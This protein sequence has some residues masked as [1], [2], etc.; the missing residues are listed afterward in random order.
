MNKKLT[1]WII[2]IVIVFS[3]FLAYQK[4]QGN[5]P[6]LPFQNYLGMP[7]QNAN[8]QMGQ[9]SKAITEEITDNE[10][11]APDLSVVGE[12]GY[13]TGSELA[14]AQLPNATIWIPGQ[15]DVNIT[16][17]NGFPVEGGE[18][19]G[20]Y[21]SN[22]YYAERETGDGKD[23]LG[24]LNVS[25][26]NGLRSTYVLL[27]QYKDGNLTQK[28]ALM[29]GNGVNVRQVGVK[30]PGDTGADYLVVAEI[31]KLAE[32]AEPGDAPS[33]DSRITAKVKNHQFIQ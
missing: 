17:V 25:D 28:D 19:A 6:N 30:D 31:V 4:M 21:L 29:L 7:N 11:V 23:L 32:G 24:I 20:V 22:S 1:L 26:Q 18:S 12:N 14:I 15:D 3:G 13:S 5:I 33:I 16:L 10:N 27:F 9:Y 2:L 8:N